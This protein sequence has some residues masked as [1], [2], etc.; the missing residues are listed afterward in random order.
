MATSCVAP[1]AL[2]TRMMVVNSASWFT[3]S[4]RMATSR[5]A[6]MPSCVSRIQK[7]R[8]P[9]RETVSVSTIGP[10]AHLNA[11]GR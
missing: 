9:K 5:L 7:R 1:K 2:W 3:K 4:T 10:A 11:H 6:I 8:R